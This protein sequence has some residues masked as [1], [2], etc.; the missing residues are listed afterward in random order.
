MPHEVEPVYCCTSV[1]LHCIFL[2]AAEEVTGGSIALNVSFNST[3]L[4]SLK[5]DLCQTV[6]G[7]SSLSCP[8]KEGPNTLTVAQTIPEF[9]PSVSVGLCSSYYSP[10]NSCVMCVKANTVSRIRAERPN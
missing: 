7:V 6:A 5:L 4:I 3:P 10:C 9:L 2:S 1:A 8:L